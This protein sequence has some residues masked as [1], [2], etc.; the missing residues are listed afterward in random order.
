MMT[1]M[2]LANSMYRLPFAREPDIGLGIAIQTFFDDDE[3]SDSQETRQIRLAEFP[4]VFVPYAEALEDDF[5]A[6]VEF[7]TAINEG[8]QQLGSDS[9]PPADKEAWARAQKYLEA[10]PF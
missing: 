10:R 1:L 9:L 7:V 5:R 6:C 3:A 4:R 8:I 2:A